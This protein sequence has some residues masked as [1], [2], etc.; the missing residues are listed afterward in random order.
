MD[1]IDADFKVC[2]HG[3]IPQPDYSKPLASHLVG[4]TWEQSDNIPTTAKSCDNF[5]LGS[6]VQL[7]SR[8]WNERYVAKTVACECLQEYDNAYGSRPITNQPYTH[9]CQHYFCNQIDVRREEMT[10]WRGEHSNW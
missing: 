7:S 10:A 3:I 9:N 2:I 4:F 8:Y 1:E 5:S 6:I